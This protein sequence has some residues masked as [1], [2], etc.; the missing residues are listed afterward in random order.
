MNKYTVILFYKFINIENPQALRDEQKALCKELGLLGRVLVSGEGINGTLEGETLAIEKYQ[1]ALKKNSL[2]SDLVFKRSK[3]N[4]QA[5][6]KLEIKVR[7]EAV[8]LG[9]GTFNIAEET[10][11]TLTAEELEAMYQ[12]D[13]DFIVL[14][15]RNDFEIE[16][17]RFEK[18][19]DPGLRNFRDLPNK[20]KELKEAK[21]LKGKKVVTVCTGGI[22]C[23]KATCLLKRHGFDNLYQLKDGIHTYMEKFPTSHFKGSLYVFDNRLTDPLTDSSE[24][25]IIGRCSYCSSLTESF[26]SDDNVRP[27]RKVICC[28]ECFNQRRDVLR[29]CRP[30]EEVVRE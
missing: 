22:R 20:L 9:A 25:E 6:T 19:F 8:T 11:P 7:S 29:S 15:L 24:R 2:F 28:E 30:P 26:Y 17:G 4:G 16:V 21:E 1:E 23:E 5:F 14:D 18:T 10:A 13:E 3:G 12:K 27:S